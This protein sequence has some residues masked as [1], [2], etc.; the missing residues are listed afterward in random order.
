M[1]G[2]ARETRTPMANWPLRPQRSASTSS[3]TAAK[4]CFHEQF[5]RIGQGPTSLVFSNPLIIEAP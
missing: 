5:S 1:N 4:W 3:A 2:A